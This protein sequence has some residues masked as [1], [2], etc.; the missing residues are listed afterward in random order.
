M[1]TS[2]EIAAYLQTIPTV[3]SAIPCTV[4]IKGTSYPATRYTERLQNSPGTRA[5]DEGKREYTREMIYVV[6]SLPAVKRNGNVAFN[7]QGDTRDWY[8]A[9]YFPSYSGRKP[10]PVHAATEYQP[11]RNMFLL[12]PWDNLDTKIDT[13]ERVPY[14]RVAMALSVGE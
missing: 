1:T 4:T 13:Y 12:S 11:F 8:V 6:G 3:T 9:G 2:Q 7:L 14:K 10:Q 5:Y